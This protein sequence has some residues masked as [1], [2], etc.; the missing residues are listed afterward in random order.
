MLFND[1]TSLINIIIYYTIFE[2]QYGKRVVVVPEKKAKELLKNEEKKKKTSVLST[3]WKQLNW[4]EQNKIMSQNTNI[5]DPLTGQV[6]FDVYKFR[7]NRVKTCLKEWNLR[8]DNNNPIPI[9]PEKI[10]QL[11]AD[12]VGEL[13][14]EY[15]KVTEWSKADMEKL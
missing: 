4:Q 5:T 6:Q 13:L 7:D 8:D 1:K 12:I 14:T 2:D 11:P 15:E 9:T 3:K 10:D